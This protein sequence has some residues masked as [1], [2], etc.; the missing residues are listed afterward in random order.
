MQLEL[1]KQYTENLIKYQHMVDGIPEWIDFAKEGYSMQK[2][3]KFTKLY[4][5]ESIKY[6]LKE[7]IQDGEISDDEMVEANKLIQKAIQ[8]YNE[9]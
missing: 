2:Y 8:E 9:M 5:I 7:A 1:P 4:E 3:R 6:H